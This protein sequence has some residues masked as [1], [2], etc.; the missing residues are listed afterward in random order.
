M[1]QHWH[2]LDEL[3]QQHAG[4]LRLDAER[5]R[6][7]RQLPRRPSTLRLALASACRSLADRLEPRAVCPDRVE[8]ATW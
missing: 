5:E 3:W 2:V 4:E 1:V 7:A 6:L 8:P